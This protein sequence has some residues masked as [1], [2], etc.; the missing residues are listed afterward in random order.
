MTACAIETLCLV[1]FGWT[2]T[3]V[4]ALIRIR[5]AVLAIRTY[6]KVRS[7]QGTKPKNANEPLERLLLGSGVRQENDEGEIQTYKHRC[8]GLEETC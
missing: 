4:P 7:M 6:L 8:P 1:L 3:A 2:I 5:F